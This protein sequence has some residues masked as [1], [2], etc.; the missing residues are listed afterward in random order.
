MGAD[1]AHTRDLVG[2]IPTNL[3][4][5]A[6]RVLLDFIYFFSNFSNLTLWSTQFA[7][8]FVLANSYSFFRFIFLFYFL[9]DSRNSGISCLHSKRPSISESFFFKLCLFVSF[10]FLFYFVYAFSP[11]FFFMHSHFLFSDVLIKLSYSM[12]FLGLLFFSQRVSLIR[13]ITHFNN[14]LIPYLYLFSLAVSLFIFSTLN[15]YTVIFI[16]EFLNLLLLNLLLLSWLSTYSSAS[17]SSIFSKTIVSSAVFFFFISV[18]SSF[19]LFF[20]LFLFFIL[21]GSADFNFISIITN[22]SNF[23]CL[24]TPYMQFFLLNTFNHLDFLYLIFFTIIVFKLGFPPFLVWKIFLFENST[25]LFLVLYNFPYFVLSFLYFIYLIF[26]LLDFSSM[27]PSNLFQ[28]I[29]FISF[30][31]FTPFVLKSN[32]WGS[33]FAISSAFTTFFILYMLFLASS[34]LGGNCFG[35]TLQSP[36]VGVFQHY[37]S[38]FTA[39]FFSYLLSLFFFLLLLD[40]FAVLFGYESASSLSRTSLFL[41]KLDYSLWIRGKVLIIFFFFLFSALPPFFPFFAK[42]IIL[43]SLNFF[44]MGLFFIFVVSYFYIMLVFYFKFTKYFLNQA[45]NVSVPL[46]TQLSSAG[47]SSLTTLSLKLKNSLLSHSLVSVKLSTSPLLE[48][49]VTLSQTS[50]LLFGSFFIWFSSVGLFILTD[51]ILFL[52]F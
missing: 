1:T 49:W 22:F 33:F 29:G 39:Y 28:F 42:L 11:E 52:S 21:V 8:L 15:Y 30:F 19:M 32:S 34:T 38:F 43:M 40:S 36:S 14:T 25:L 23:Y 35:G 26:I 13:F 2:S 7:V 17:P 48:A 24:A 20:S 6:S 50:R 10:L 44:K 3:L 45:S 4:R 47:G 9:I 51:I 37:F 16:I 5:T 31:F 41:V 27:T 18:F 12:F 46:V